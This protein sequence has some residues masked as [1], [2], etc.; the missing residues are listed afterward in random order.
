M[1]NRYITAEQVLDY[2]NGKATAGDLAFEGMLPT[3][4]DIQ[5]AMESAAREWN[6][7]PPYISTARASCLPNDT[8]I[9]FD[10]IAFHLLCREK[11]KLTREDIDYSAGGVQANLVKARLK[12]IDDQAKFYF[13][14]FQKAAREKKTAI[15]LSRANGPVG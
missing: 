3:P 8:N 9:L 13:E 7:V 1:R 12:H 6:D 14:K 5:S 15:N 11:Q 10:A 2:V 4:E